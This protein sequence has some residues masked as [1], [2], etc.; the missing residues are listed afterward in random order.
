MASYAHLVLPADAIKALPATDKVHFLNPNGRRANRSLGDVTDLNALGVHVIEVPVGAESTELHVHFDEEEFLY[1]LSGRGI[2]HLD[3]ERYP[4][5]AGTFVAFPTGGP[6]HLI[7]NP[8]P[9]TLRCLV[10]GQR[11]RHDRADYPRLEK[12]LYRHPGGWDLVDHDHVV[13]PKA[14]RGSTAGSK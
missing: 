12:R 7:E 5:E 10:V 1:V 9:E 11:L 3:D 6:A 13:D 4:V 8:G 14:R 2:V